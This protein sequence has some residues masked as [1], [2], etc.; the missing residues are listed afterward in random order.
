M[1]RYLWACAAS[2][3]AM[4][5]LDVLWLGFVARPLYQNGLGHLMAERPNL[6]AAAAFYLLYGLGL[7]VFAVMPHVGESG[8]RSTAGT[9]ALFG[10][11]AYATYDL[12]NLA[13]LRDWPL[14]LS[15]IDMAWGGAASA[16]SAVAGKAAFDWS[17]AAG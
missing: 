6:A 11:L 17:Q 10:L 8:W 7:T 15:L 4:I 5:A 16:I 12:S 2:V 9:A 13:T 14:G 3:L 1:N